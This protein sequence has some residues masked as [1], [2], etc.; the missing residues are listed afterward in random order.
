[1]SGG[2]RQKLLYSVVAM[3]L[4]IAGA[5][6]ILSGTTVRPV[7]EEKLSR[8]ALVIG[9]QFATGSESG[10][11]TREHVLLSLRL[12]KLVREEKGVEYA[13]L[14]DPKGKVIAHSFEGGFPAGLAGV[15]TL[16]AGATESIR[17][18]RTGRGDI[19]D[20]A[21]PILG[22]RLGSA[23]VGMSEKIVER[24]VNEILGT[25]VV[26]SIGV[27][28]AMTL[29]IILIGANATKP[30]LELSRVVKKVG[31]GSNEER[32]TVRSRDEVGELAHAFNEM[33]AARSEHDRE[34]ERLVT[35][36]REALDR[37]RTLSGFL[38]I[39]SY[40]KKIRDDHGYWNAI[41]SYISE[42]SEAEFSHG[43]CDDC[44]KKLH[45]EL[46]SGQE[47]TR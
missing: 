36:L 41:E 31:E 10:I 8:H 46:A 45:P 17:P 7:L 33:I 19:L 25:M 12:R 47:E 5:L 28:A 18:V 35:E 44:M 14:L 9:R 1:M 39:C 34:R 43:V 29:M 32:A 11:L 38:P 30:I 20:A 13:Y 37:V 2:L 42:H 4:L 15:N 40:C 6:F 26:L 24:D 21:V 22:G 27:I 3:A 23:H 16:P